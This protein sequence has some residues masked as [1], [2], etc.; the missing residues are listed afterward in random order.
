MFKKFLRGLENTIWIKKNNDQ[1][2]NF[3]KIDIKIEYNIIS[4]FLKVLQIN[5]I[6]ACKLIINLFDEKI[7][8]DL[9]FKTYI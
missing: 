5:F 7:I 1:S 2:L 6:I 9:I 3:I 4:K 8:K